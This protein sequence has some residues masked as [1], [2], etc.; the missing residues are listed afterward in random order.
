MEIN[1]NL[2]TLKKEVGK[3]SKVFKKD[4]KIIMS[5]AL[6]VFGYKDGLLLSARSGEV[7][8]KTFV[9][10]DVKDPHFFSVDG[11]LFNNYLNSIKD[12]DLKLVFNPQKEMSLIMTSKGTK[13][14][15]RILD[16][17]THPVD[18][19]Y[20]QV[21]FTTVP[22]FFK[23]LEKV[24]FAASK[25]STRPFLESVLLTSDHVVSSDMYTLAYSSFGFDLPM[26][27]LIPYSS[28]QMIP[29]CIK[30]ED[31]V[32]I[33]FSSDDGFNAHMLHLKSGNNVCT[34]RLLDCNKFVRYQDIVKKVGL[35]SKSVNI[36]TLTVSEALRSAKSITDKNERIE[37]S[38]YENGIKISFE[39]QETSF[40]QFIEEG[41]SFK[42]DQ[43]I[44]LSFY[45]KLDIAIAFFE[46]PVSKDVKL[47]IRSALEPVFIVDNGDIYAA[48]PLKGK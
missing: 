34:V 18:V 3:L 45:I 26:K 4:D 30:K 9:N 10:C 8:A 15:L 27:A 11:L 33:A 22:S 35:N 48:M 29:E 2:D 47:L 23:A 13:S 42:N 7:F 24:K 12:N 1:I 31:M 5:K 20:E 6:S 17:D 16:P 28:I 38:V 14:K 25:D 46:A 40:E 36:N 32:D 21:R 44:A 37:F 41:E 39:N 19:D 43:K